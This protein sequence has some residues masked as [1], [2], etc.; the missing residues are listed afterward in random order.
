[1][2]VTSVWIEQ[3]CKIY[4]KMKYK[5]KWLFLSAF[6]LFLQIFGGQGCGG[7]TEEWSQVIPQTKDIHN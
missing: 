4:T 1:M 2:Y 5:Q 3:A 7:G 6:L